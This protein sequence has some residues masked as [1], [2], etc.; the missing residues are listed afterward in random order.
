MKL[1]AP[2]E[3]VGPVSDPA[4]W[5]WKLRAVETEFL[6][7]AP[8]HASIKRFVRAPK[9]NLGFSIVTM[10]CHHDLTVMTLLMF[11]AIEP[12]PLLGQPFAKCCAFHRV[13]S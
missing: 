8:D 10:D 3:A 2:R 1:I 6:A 13:L 12:A 5:P 7:R 4:L 9:R 11:V